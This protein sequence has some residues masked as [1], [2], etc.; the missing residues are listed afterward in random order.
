MRLLGKISSVSVFIALVL[1]INTGFTYAISQQDRDAILKSTLYYDPA[2]VTCL[3][4]NFSG[5]NNTEIAFNYF[6]SK[7]LTEEQS[8]GLVGNF[9]VE[10][11]GTM[12][13]KIKQGGGIITDPTDTSGSPGRGIAQWE[14]HEDGSG[15]WWNLLAFAE[16]LNRDPLALE[17][18]LDFVMFELAGQPQVAGVTGGNA[19]RAYQELTAA[20]SVA[21]AAFV[22]SNYYEINAAALAWRDGK[23]TYEEAFGSRIAA[24]EEVYEAF[25]GNGGGQLNEP[26][27]PCDG[28][29]GGDIDIIEGDTTHI[30]C[31]GNILNEYE[32][33]GYKDGNRYR[34]RICVL[35]LLDGSAGPHVNSQI[36]GSMSRMFDSAWS[37]GVEMNGGGFR[38]MEE[39]IQAR[40]RNGCP[41]IYDSPA[42][43]CRIPTARPGYSNH[44]MGLAIDFNGVG[45][46]PSSTIID[47]QKFCQAPGNDTWEWL[48]ANAS[49]YGLQQ[50]RT[51][52]WHWSVDGK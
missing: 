29:G 47:G 11:A 35:E 20:T 22:V 8:A 32:A 2:A 28:G 4:G 10:T 13:P 36:S 43:A 1:F 34:I 45:L 6:V 52:A 27:N 15:R 19:A 17:T 50:L 31:V 33:D 42:S 5:S 46:C 21:D 14:F 40:I 51:E 30:Q 3:S 44:Q 7:G 39:Q 12:D 26:V 18:Q 48:T 23:L 38:T 41:D 9:L 24:A 37:I 16:A 49:R 25:A